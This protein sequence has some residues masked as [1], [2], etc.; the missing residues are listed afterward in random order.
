VSSKALH[1]RLTC[2][3][4]PE[5]IFDRLLSCREGLAF[6]WLGNLSWLIRGGGRLVAFDLDLDSPPRLDPPPISA[7]E[8][9]PALD[10]VFITHEHEDHFNPVTAGKLAKASR[11]LFVLPANCVDKAHSLE[12]PDSRIRIAR[13][14]EPMD[15][16]GLRV[17]P[18]RA[19]HGDR[20]LAVYRHANLDDCGYVLTIAGRRILQP[21]DSVLLQDHLMETGL[22]VL[23]VSPTIHNMHVAPAV[24]LIRAFQPRFIFPQHFD[25]YRQ[26]PDNEFWTHGYPDE[27]KAA[28]WPELRRRF[29]KLRQGEVF[30][31][32]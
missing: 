17:E 10:A 9:G 4:S 22:D 21:G 16:L 28:L 30:V 19:L 20:C 6:C 24:A 26:T 7:N 32:K 11:C 25:T 5:P 3:N 14:R 1:G 2:L 8:I 13:P 23:F 15:L 29:H 12:I 27:L 18:L 31:A